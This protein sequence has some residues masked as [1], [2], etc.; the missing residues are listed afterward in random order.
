VPTCRLRESIAGALV[1]AGLLGLCVLDAPPAVA[2]ERAGDATYVY[3]LE[4][5][6]KDESIL[7]SEMLESIER[8]PEGERFGLY[9]ASN[10]LTGAWSQV[11][12]LQSLLELSIGVESTSL[13]AEFRTT[14]R[15]QAQFVL[16]EIGETEQ[17]LAQDAMETAQHEQLR[18]NAAIRALLAQVANTVRRLQADDPARPDT[19]IDSPD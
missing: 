5:H 11:E 8:R 7:E 1:T 12:F 3:E 19:G 17:R 4:Q 18:M 16:W 10:H 2:R 13:E 6:A 15:G 14:L 9:Q